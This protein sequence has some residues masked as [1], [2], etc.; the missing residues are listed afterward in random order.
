MTRKGLVVILW[1]PLT[2]ILL[3]ANLT[4][5]AR[6]GR[7][8]STDKFAQTHTLSSIGSLTRLTATANTGQVL[9]DEIIP[10]DARD[11]LIASFLS[12][13]NSPMAPYADEIVQQADAY[14]IDFRLISAI[15]MCESNAG[16]FMPTSDSYNAWGIAVY[17]GKNTGKTFSNWS[18]GIEWVS[19]Y[20]KEKFYDRG[21]SDL[22]EISK[23]WAPP[24]VENGYSWSNCVEGFIRSI[25]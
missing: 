14:G 23:T 10:G 25:R 24:S 22:R 18:H 15:A 16:K 1:F 11:L 9:G 17:T 4:L 13:H 7:Q 21:I 6:M 2:T 19:R 3:I 20:I 12:A 8:G 5:L